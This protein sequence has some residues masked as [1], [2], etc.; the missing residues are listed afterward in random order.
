[1]RA[2]FGEPFGHG[3]LM[4]VKSALRDNALANQL[5]KISAACSNLSEPTF[6]V[7]V[8]RQADLGSVSATRILRAAL[9]SAAVLHTGDCS[10]SWSSMR[11]H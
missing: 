3:N 2:I 10:G 9:P 4:K 6:M 5:W 8:C 1:M 11:G 7:T